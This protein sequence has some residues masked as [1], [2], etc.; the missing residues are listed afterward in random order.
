MDPS[1]INRGGLLLTPGA[2]GSGAVRG[3]SGQLYL[4]LDQ[5]LA[6]SPDYAWNMAHR[7]GLSLVAFGTRRRTLSLSILWQ[8]AIPIGLGP[9]AG[10]SGR[11]DPGRGGRWSES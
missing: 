9:G 7:L 3:V 5:K 11:A 8:M 10:H 4:G 1:G 6:D 2:L